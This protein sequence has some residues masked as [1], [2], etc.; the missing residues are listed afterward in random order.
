MNLGTG[1]Y[2]PEVRAFF[3]KLGR[4]HSNGIRKGHAI[5]TACKTGD[6]KNHTNQ[7]GNRQDWEE[8]VGIRHTSTTTRRAIKAMGTAVI[9]AADPKGLLDRLIDPSIVVTA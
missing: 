6:T 9:K 5:C 8:N 3:P 4:G 1:R 2:Q 7:A